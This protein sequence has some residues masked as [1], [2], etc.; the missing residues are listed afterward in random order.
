MNGIERCEMFRAIRKRLCENN[1]IPYLEEDCPHPNEKCIGTCPECDHWLERINAHLNLKR[2]NG[3]EIDFSGLEEI[4]E[5]FIAKSIA[6]GH[7]N[8]IWDKDRLMGFIPADY[9]DK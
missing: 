2:Q 4:Y 9:D 5:S 7:G 8:S 1:G 6:A 3:E